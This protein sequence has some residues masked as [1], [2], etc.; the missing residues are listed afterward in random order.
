MFLLKWLVIPVGLAAVGFFVVGPM[1]ARSSSTPVAAEPPAE[2]ATQEPTNTKVTGNPEVEVSARP[3][4]RRRST[5]RSRPRPTNQESPPSI[6]SP[7]EEPPRTGP[8][9]G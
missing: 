9:G 7:D 5:R 6:P 1:L 2:P 4:P 3:A 8:D